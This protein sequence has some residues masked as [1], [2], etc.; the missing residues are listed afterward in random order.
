[1]RAT[2]LLLAERVHNLATENEEM[3]EALETKEEA[4][5]ELRNEIASL[6]TELAAKCAGLDDVS[7]RFSNWKASEREFTR[8][9]KA[10]IKALRNTR[11]KLMKVTHNPLNDFTRKVFSSHIV[12]SS[13]NV[14][15]FLCAVSLITLHGLSRT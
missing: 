6:R 13:H 1:L 5:K 3:A 12:F 15:C 9:T 2:Q 7:V 8:K 10:K 4:D 14:I 11:D